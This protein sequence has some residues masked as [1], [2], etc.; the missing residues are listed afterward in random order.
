MEEKAFSAVIGG[1]VQGVGFRWNAAAAARRLGLTGWVRNTDNGYVEI[2]A[3]GETRALKSLI[4]WL[5]EGPPGARVDRVQ[6]T[7][8]RPRGVYRTFGIEHW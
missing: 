5:N 7:W 4:D 3:E 8:E 6:V 1:R 2:W